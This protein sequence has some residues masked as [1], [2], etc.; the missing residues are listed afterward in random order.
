MVSFEHDFQEGQTL[1]GTEVGR[2]GAVIGA[3]VEVPLE[4]SASGGDTWD[5][6]ACFFIDFEVVLIEDGVI[7][8]GVG[9]GVIGEDVAFGERIRG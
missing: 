3:I 1:V 9:E 2:L 5:S 4:G 7:G 6:L 8:E